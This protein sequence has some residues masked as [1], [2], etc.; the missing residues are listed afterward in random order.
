MT[1]EGGGGGVRGECPALATPQGHRMSFISVTSSV[2]GLAGEVLA[3][4]MVCFV[5]RMNSV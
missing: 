4:T 5:Y 3:S 1:E 2:S